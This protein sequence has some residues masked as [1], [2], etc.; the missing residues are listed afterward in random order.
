MLAARGIVLLRSRRLLR[1]SD[2]APQ[3][4]QS[5][6]SFSVAVRSFSLSILVPGSLPGSVHPMSTSN[7][8]AK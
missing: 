8:A 5:I 4:A 1:D 7:P 2:D 3:S 6:E